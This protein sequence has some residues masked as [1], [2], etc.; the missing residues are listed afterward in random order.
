MRLLFTSPTF[1]FI[2][3]FP[4]AVLGAFQFNRKQ[5]LFLAATLAPALIFPL[6]VID[7]RYL[8]PLLPA[9]MLWAARGLIVADN[10]VAQTL[11]LWVHRRSEAELARWSASLKRLAFLNRNLVTLVLLALFVAADIGAMFFIPR[12]TEFRTAG[13]AL[14]GTLAA[15]SPVLMRK[16]Q[17]GFYANVN[18]ESLPFSDLQ[19]VFD[20]AAQKRAT[21]FELDSRTTPETRPQLA[22]LLQQP[23]PASV[24]I[25]YDAPKNQR[26]MI[27]RILP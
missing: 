19:G 9:G 18:Y 12:P 10:K 2:L 17:L 27:F 3:W 25:I 15:Q 11:S 24:Q 7:G 22:Y 26:V 23:A 13:L 1:L 5:N 6:S 21:Y 14:R 4:F 8:L 16:R 20:Y